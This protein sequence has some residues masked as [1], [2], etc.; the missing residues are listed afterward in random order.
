ML[1][2]DNVYHLDCFKLIE[3][4]D[5]ETVDLVLV[6]PPYNMKKASWDTFHSHQDFLDFTYSWIEAIIPKIKSTG[7]FYI[8]NTPFN[9]AYI[10]QYLVESKMVFQNWITWDKR[11]G[12]GGAKKRYSNGQ[13]TILFFTKSRDYTFNY[14]DIRLPYDSQERIRAAEKKGILKNGKRWFPNPDGKLCGEVWRDSSERHQ[15]KLNGKVVKLP[16]KTIKPKSMIERIILASSNPGDLVVDFFVGSGTTAIVSKLNDRHY[17][18]GD[19]NL[20]FVQLAENSL[21]ELKN[22]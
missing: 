10:L 7:S 16:H 3:Q 6:D 2:L 8:F 19:S 18:C 22:N 20:E 12:L 9:S 14:N 11:D 21:N 17:I 5:D 15:R 4:L 1:D 13:E